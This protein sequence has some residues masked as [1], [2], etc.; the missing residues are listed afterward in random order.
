MHILQRASKCDITLH[1]E[2]QWRGTQALSCILEDSAQAEHTWQEAIVRQL[3]IL[4]YITSATYNAFPCAQKF[5]RAIDFKQPEAPPET[6]L[7]VS[8]KAPS[9]SG[10][11]HETHP[12]LCSS[13]R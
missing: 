8:Q 13:C 1:I 4:I 10:P 2:A 9:L 7:I 12:D 3:F 5:S 6:G 11:I